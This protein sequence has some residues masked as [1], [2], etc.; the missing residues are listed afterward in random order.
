VE[1][2]LPRLS[3][4][5]KDV[6][7]VLWHSDEYLTASAVAEKG[8][9]SI[10]TVQANMRSLMKKEYIAVADIVYSGTVLSRS[11]KPVISAEKYAAEQLREIRD[12]A[13][14]FSTLNFMGNFLKKEDKDTLEELE[15]LIK[16]KK[17]E[18]GE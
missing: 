13:L 14:S 8:E 9:I 7:S 18:E 4:R 5:E 16:S 3:E 2:K 6:M 1:N 11:Y 15:K 12:N 10:N 17:E